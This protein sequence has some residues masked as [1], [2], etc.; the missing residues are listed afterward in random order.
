[1]MVCDGS[2]CHHEI[3]TTEEHRENQHC[4]IAYMRAYYQRPDMKEK[5]RAYYQRRKSGT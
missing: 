4:K 3:N 1:M 2:N 5:K